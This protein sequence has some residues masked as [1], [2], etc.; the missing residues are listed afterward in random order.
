ML[1]SLVGSEMCI[2]DRNGKSERYFKLR[3]E[4]DEELKQLQINYYDRE[5]ERLTTPG[6]VSYN[7][8]KNL[9]TPM[10][11]SNWNPLLLY[12]GIDPDIARENMADFFNGISSEFKGLE[13]S[14]LPLTF[15]RQLAEIHF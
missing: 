8:L 4:N 9:N 15:D 13:E 1:R 3:K 2:R 7:A 6:A 5:C 10:R 11:P 14:D 12:P